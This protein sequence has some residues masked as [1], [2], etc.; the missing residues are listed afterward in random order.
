MLTSPANFRTVCLLSL[1]GRVL[2]YVLLRVAPS[3]KSAGVG[4]LLAA[5]QRG[6]A[7]CRVL[8][9]IIRG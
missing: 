7:F 5:A 6:A 2:T 3:A 4:V 9:V 1:P 8:A